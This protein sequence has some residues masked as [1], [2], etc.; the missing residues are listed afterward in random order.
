MCCSESKGAVN[1]PATVP[2]TR[3]S[4]VAV[5]SSLLRRYSVDILPVQN[6]SS[7]AKSRTKQPG[8]S[9]YLRQSSRSLDSESPTKAKSVLRGLRQRKRSETQRTPAHNETA[10]GNSTES[11][12]VTSPAPLNVADAIAYGDTPS[13]LTLWTVNN[14]SSPEGSSS[15][16]SP[17]RVSSTLPVVD[18]STARVTSSR[19]RDLPFQFLSTHLY[20][21]PSPLM[22]RDLPSTNPR[23]DVPSTVSATTTFQGAIAS[24]DGSDSTHSSSEQQQSGPNEAQGWVHTFHSNSTFENTAMDNPPTIA[25]L[26]ELAD[27]ASVSSDDEIQRLQD[28][29]VTHRFIVPSQFFAEGSTFNNDGMGPEMGQLVSSIHAHEWTAED[30]KFLEDDAWAAQFEQRQQEFVESNSMDH[31][32]EYPHFTHY[33]SYGQPVFPSSPPKTAPV[34]LD[35]LWQ[36]RL[37]LNRQKAREKIS[38]AFSGSRMRGPR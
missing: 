21:V 26:P 10:A 36:A 7:R 12:L 2:R 37:A 28:R 6:I 30:A 17:L 35:R 4:G 13:P 19:V 20:D 23:P 32:P 38:P 3:H 27:G 25:A 33:D 24:P 8:L 34:N 29:W 31:R 9:P 14:S 5:A 15:H 16:P 1:F 22:P 11:P 18:S